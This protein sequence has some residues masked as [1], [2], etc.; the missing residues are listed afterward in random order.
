MPKAWT[1]IWLSSPRSFGSTT[2]SH[3]S[4]YTTDGLIRGSSHT[5]RKKAPNR[6]GHRRG[7]EREQQ[8][9]RDVEDAE[10]GHDEDGGDAERGE[11]ARVARGHP[12]E[13]LQRERRDRERAAHVG[14]REDHVDDDR[15]D[16]E[17]R[18]QHQR[19][20]EE[21]GEVGALSA[22]LGARKV[23]H[24]ELLAGRSAREALPSSLGRS[25]RPTF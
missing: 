25:G 9:E 21:Q 13:I 5:A 3:S 19:R 11:Q 24:G 17:A 14:E 1:R 20:P 8:R 4:A 22:Q 10:C 23:G 16:E 18:E 12:L 7:D 2:H 6:L 15:R